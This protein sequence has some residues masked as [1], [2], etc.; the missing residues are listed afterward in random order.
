[1]ESEMLEKNNDSP[2]CFVTI[3]L[4]AA[5]AAARVTELPP[6]CNNKEGKKRRCL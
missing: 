2:I 3:G 6:R 4:D 5:V 1:M